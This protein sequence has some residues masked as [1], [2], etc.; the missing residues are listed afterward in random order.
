MVARLLLNE[1]EESVEG[2]AVIAGHAS[3]EEQAILPGAG[4]LASIAIFGVEPDGSVSG[5]TI[6]LPLS[7]LTGGATLVIGEDGIAGGVWTIPAGAAAP[8]SFSPFITGTLQLSEAGTEPGAAIV[9]SG[10]GARRGHCRQLLRLL[11]A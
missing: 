8:D 1:N 7:Q 9:G 5:L 3:P 6:V 2:V 11:R 4:E 10:N